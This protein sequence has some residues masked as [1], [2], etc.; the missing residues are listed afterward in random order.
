MKD[1]PLSARPADQFR[2]A[3]KD[4]FVRPGS[5][6]STPAGSWPNAAI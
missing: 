3:E 6:R 1:Y 4:Y 2:Q 5:S